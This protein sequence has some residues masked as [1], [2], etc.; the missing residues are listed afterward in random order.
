MT[1]PSDRAKGATHVE[2]VELAPAPDAQLV[3]A[4]LGLQRRQRRA[5]LDRPQLR[6]RLRCA[7]HPERAPV[8]AQ[9]RD[10]L[11]NKGLTQAICA[12]AARRR[13]HPCNDAPW[14]EAKA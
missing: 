5:E 14:T 7:R 3:H 9:Q 13:Q 2:Q 8:Q 11:L 6:P 10:T 4:L 1:G 12:H